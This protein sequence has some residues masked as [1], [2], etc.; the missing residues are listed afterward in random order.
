MIQFEAKGFVQFGM[1]DV[2]VVVEGGDG[3]HAGHVA[4]AHVAQDGCGVVVEGDH[5]GDDR[6]VGILQ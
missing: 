6:V 1:C 4:G 5:G 3:H 2:A